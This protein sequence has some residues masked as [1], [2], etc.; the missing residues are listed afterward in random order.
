MHA[1]CPSHLILLDLNTVITIGEEVTVIVN[2]T[3]VIKCEKYQYTTV[4]PNVSGLA[5]W[6]ETCI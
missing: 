2:N 4:D 1:T 5:A 3:S 6:S